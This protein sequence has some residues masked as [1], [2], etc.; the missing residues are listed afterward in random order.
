MKYL[1]Y[2]KE[3]LVRFF[4]VNISLKLDVDPLLAIFGMSYVYVYV[5]S[6]LGV[7]TNVNAL[8]TYTYFSYILMFTNWLI[9]YAITNIVS[10]YAG[11]N[12]ES[13]NIQLVFYLVMFDIL[14]YYL[15][16]LMHTSILWKVHSVH[17]SATVSLGVDALYMHP[18]EVCLTMCSLYLSMLV[19][20]PSSQLVVYN[21]VAICAKNTMWA[22]CR[23]ESVLMPE[24]AHWMHHK[25]YL[26]NYGNI[27]MDFVF[28]T[29]QKFD[30]QSS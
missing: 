22:H 8:F 7:Y 24:S 17:H 16:R 12:T 13:D 6:L 1:L 2:L 21:L 19:W 3:I 9:A 18:I 26:V 14:Y 28:S 10:K 30:P 20:P 29:Y 27:F 23:V 25:H 15:H 4:I 5:N 11:D